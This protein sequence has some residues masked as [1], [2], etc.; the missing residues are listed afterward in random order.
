MG[1]KIITE[2]N[3]PVMQFLSKNTVGAVEEAEPMPSKTGSG[4]QAEAIPEG[5]EIRPER[6]A[7]RLQ[8]LVQPTVLA[9]IKDIAKSK[10]L[11]TNEYVNQ[12]F[13]EAIEKE[14]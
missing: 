3:N 1:K 10:N 12:L 5:Y 8:L 13:R 14:R 7:K 2:E 6:K 9:T 4:G 11:S